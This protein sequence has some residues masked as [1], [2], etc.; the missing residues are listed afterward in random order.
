MFQ[1]IESAVDPK[2]PHYGTR[3]VIFECESQD[4]AKCACD[5]W[6]RQSFA[7]FTHHVY[8]DCGKPIY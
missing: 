3:S 1:V 6:R 5:M 7:G 4:E 2:H 8:D